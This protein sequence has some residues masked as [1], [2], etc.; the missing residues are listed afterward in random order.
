MLM[1]F[2]AEALERTTDDAIEIYDR[3]LGGA[4]R[5]AQRKREELE[6]RARRDTQAAVRTFIDLSGVILE[7]HDGGGDVLR[8]IE[9]RIGI[10]R[11]R[12]D[13]DR[14]QGIVR[15]TDTGHLD[16]LIADGGSGG[17][18]LLAAVNDSLELR[19][20]G[21]D[22]DGLLAALRLVRQLVGDRRRWLPGFSPSAFIDKQWRPHVVDAAR[23]RLDRRSYELCAAYE[24]RAAL[25]AGRV[26]VPGSRR[27]ADPASLLLPDQQW[28]AS[29]ATFARAVERPLDGTERLDAPRRGAARAT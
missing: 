2:C 3:A 19:A 9:R 24:L 14:A 17:R 16:L 5:A 8:M 21:R 22:E 29:Q 13:R 12:A 1:A 4:D 10:E 23:G 20:A 11:L 18:K 27:H 6:R 26:W 28:Q 7:A 15:P 25:R